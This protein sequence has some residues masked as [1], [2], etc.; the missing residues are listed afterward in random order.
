MKKRNNLIVLLFLLFGAIALFFI[1]M[2]GGHGWGGDFA[3]YICQARNFVEGIPQK[4]TGYIL[5]RYNMFAP[6]VYPVGF[7]LMLAPLYALFGNNT[8]AFQFLV[9]FFSAGIFI[10]SWFF[11]KKET[12]IILAWLAAFLLVWH[13]WVL[14]NKGEILSDIPFTFFLL[15]TIHVYL[16]AREIPKKYLTGFL[17][18]FTLLIRPVG[19]AF[20]I[21][22]GINTLI[23]GFAAMRKGEF[24]TFLRSDFLTNSVIAFTGLGIYLITNQVLVDIPY[25]GSYFDIIDYY[26]WKPYVW[27]NMVHYFTI[28]G[29]FF[30]PE[31]NVVLKYVFGFF[32]LISLITGLLQVNA[33]NR[34]LVFIIIAHIIILISVP[35]RQGFRLLYPVMPFLIYFMV[36]GWNYISGKA[37]KKPFL[38]PSLIAV[39]L[40][41]TFLPGDYEIYKTGEKRKGKGQMSAPDLEGLVYVKE[42]TPADARILFDKPRVMALYGERQ[43]M[44][45]GFS[46]IDLMHQNLIDKEIDYILV[47]TWILKANPQLKEYLEVRKENL[48]LIWQSDRYL[49]YEFIPS[50]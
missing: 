7:P 31:T 4:D 26:S 14:E 3:Q 40:I 25:E 29:D 33:R 38:V 49:L 28:F 46:G 8:L 34:I 15:L 9:T 42:H 48:N 1:N 27:E 18:G 12:G 24:N 11:Y 47:H 50:P 39:V 41:S 2:T 23:Q 32:L 37:G 21:G 43:S 45:N 10:L 36:L 16:N 30:F 5:N 19:V 20:I 17:L 22:L 44:K 35:F 6:Q 13:P